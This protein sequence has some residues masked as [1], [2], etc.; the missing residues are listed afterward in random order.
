MSGDLALEILGYVASALIAISLMMRSI[1]RLRWINLIGSVCFTIYGVLIEAYPVAVVNLAIAFIN[2]DFLVNMRRSKEAFAVVE[3]GRE[4]AYLHEFLSFH[5]ADSQSFQ[6]GFA[7]T[8][9]PGQRIFV[10]LRDLVP[11]GVVVTEPRDEP[12]RTWVSLDYVTPAYRDYRIGDYLFNRRRDLFR[13]AG[14]D[15]LET[16]AGTPAHARCLQR[17]GFRRRGETFL[18]ELVPG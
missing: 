11:A 15:R 14:L 1:I 2:V 7:F 3:M 12:G 5:G 17:V 18:L 8:E 10:V 9:R 13:S 6:P 16:A 4:S